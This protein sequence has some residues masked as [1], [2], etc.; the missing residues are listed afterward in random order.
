MPGEPVENKINWAGGVPANGA[1][2]SGGKADVLAI[3]LER[4]WIKFVRVL[5]WGMVAIGTPIGLALIARAG[6]STALADGTEEVFLGWGRMIL[7]IVL[8]VGGANLVWGAVRWI[9]RWRREKWGA[10]KVIGKLIGGGIWRFFAVAPVVLLS[11]LWLAPICVAGVGRSVLAKRNDDDFNAAGYLLSDYENGV[12]TAEEYLNYMIAAA[13]NIEALPKEYWDGKKMMAP[14]LL[15][16]ASEHLDELGAETLQEVLEISDL[17]NVDFDIDASGN[18]TSR[19]SIFMEPAY[20]LTK[21]VTTLNKAVLSEGGKFVV[22]YT[23]KGDDKV[24]D[25]QAGELAEMMEEIV[26]GYKEKLSQEYSYKFYEQS[27][28]KHK[29]IQKVL[30]ANGI[31]KEAL[32]TAMAVYVTNPYKGASNILASYAGENFLD[33]KVQIALKVGSLMPGENADMSRLYGSAAG[34]PFMNI[35]PSNIEDESLNVVVAHELGHHFSDLFCRRTTEQSCNT[36]NFVDETLPNWAAIN[37]VARSEQAAGNVISGHFG[38]YVKYGACYPINQ[39]VPEP[40]K[41]NACHKKGSDTGYPAVGFLWNYAEVVPNSIETIFTAL[42][43]D[44]ALGYLYSVTNKANFKKVMVDLTQRNLTQDYDVASLKIEGT[45]P[46]EELP[47]VDL[48]SATYYN[49][50]AS[51]RYLYFS[52]SEYDNTKVEVEAPGD[53]VVSILGRKGK[54]WQV[55]E[56]HDNRAEYVIKEEDSHEAI[57]IVVTNYG[58]SAAESFGLKI[59]KVELEELVEEEVE[60]EPGAFTLLGDNCIGMNFDSVVDLPLKVYRILATYNPESDYSD[61]FE[62]LEKQNETIKSSLVYHYAKICLNQMRSNVSFE[63]MKVKIERAIGPHFELLDVDGSVRMTI[64][65]TYDPF[66][67][68]GKCYFLTRDK[69]GYTNFVQVWMSQTINGVN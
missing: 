47:C 67:T 42:T 48:C 7:Y 17:M 6:T 19:T 14:D 60:V 12:L 16:F 56:E 34:Y 52:T 45:P 65:L 5:V 2:A 53:E 59:A 33:T 26:A 66:R 18:M 13:Y 15:G 29:K 43:T 30:E 31:A 11:L 50:P 68:L 3:G 57:A 46:G 39:V 49:N 22:F 69:D 63:E 32:E 8:V 55:V 62:S 4:G 10:G 64:M 28:S 23:D 20:A 24:S 41:E 38:E 51:A 1:D 36:N 37:V 44:D 35:L 21:N 54:K 58:I 25:A 9:L 61:L 27:S 40:P